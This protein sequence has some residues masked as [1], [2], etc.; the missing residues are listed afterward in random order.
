MFWT[1]SSSIFNGLLIERTTEPL[2][3]KTR[4]YRFRLIICFLNRTSLITLNITTMA[5]IQQRSLLNCFRLILN[6]K[7]K[8]FLIGVA[9]LPGLPDIYLHFCQV[10]KSLL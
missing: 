8:G 3:N 2:K 6:G 5:K 7:E 10:Q 1:G 4:R 9:G